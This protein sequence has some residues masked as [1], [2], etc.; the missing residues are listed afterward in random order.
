M[1]ILPADKYLTNSPIKQL[2]HITSELWEVLKAL[3][4][5]TLNPTRLNLIK[6]TCEIIDLQSSCQ[7][8]LEG[9]LGLSKELINDCR[10][11]VY[12]KNKIRGY[13]EVK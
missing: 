8:M 11:H 5:Y 7:T 10:D 3:I 1:E 13:Y 6:L 2:L 9:P 12:W 4:I